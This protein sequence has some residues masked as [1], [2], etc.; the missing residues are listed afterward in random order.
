MAY[1]F[2]W[3]IFFKNILIFIQKKV[4]CNLIDICLIG[5]QLLERLEWIHSK[6][7]IYR[8]IKPENFLLGLK[9]Q[10]MIY[11]VDFGM[12][13]KYRSSKT[14]KHILPKIN[15]TFSGTVRYASLNVLRGKTASRRD[16]LISLGYM[17][18][19][20]YKRELPWDF[21]MPHY[22]MD[23]M[24]QIMHL[25]NNN[26]YGI[27]FKDLP[28]QFEEYIKYTRN[29]KFEQN[30]D[31]S[32]LRSLF[33]KIIMGFY[34]DYKKLSF[35]WTNSKNKLF[36]PSNTYLRKATSHNRLLKRIKESSLNRAKRDIS[37]D[38]YSKKFVSPFIL[39]SKNNVISTLDVMSNNNSGTKIHNL[40]ISNN[41]TINENDS[42]ENNF[43]NNLTKNNNMNKKANTFKI[44]N[45]LTNFN[46]NNNNNINNRNSFI[47][48]KSIKN[49]KNNFIQ[50]NNHKNNIIQKS[51]TTN[52][53]NDIIKKNRYTINNVNNYIDNNN[54]NNNN[55]INKNN[56]SFLNSKV[57]KNNLVNN[58]NLKTTNNKSP[59]KKIHIPKNININNVSHLK[60][61]PK[62]YNT[63][64][65]NNNYRTINVQKMNYIKHYNTEKNQNKINL[66]IKSKQT[67]PPFINN[68]N[69]KLLNIN[70]IGNKNNNLKTRENNKLNAHEKKNN[71]KNLVK[72]KVNSCNVI[73]KKINNNYNTKPDNFI[74]INN[75]MYESPLKNLFKKIEKKTI[76]PSQNYQIRLK[77]N[78]QRKSVKSN[79]GIHLTD[80]NNNNINSR[81]FCI[82][83]SY[84]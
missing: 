5:I 31:Y 78:P 63:I 61:N 69:K 60:K 49:N 22:N 14:G 35:S 20:L 12:C 51:H 54:N 7:I 84:N 38:V 39:Q 67:S 80:I 46:E 64:N 83:N 17:L 56:N 45:V 73:I 30:P 2:N 75:L 8:D 13:K 57:I 72:D 47:D 81:E 68:V 50:N 25:K 4:R 82:Y 21:N 9:N 71:N 10:N 76:F 65:I 11:V 24:I 18:I 62:I 52:N 1:L 79:L 16:D 55:N 33:N 74:F 70:I 43:K 59:Y 36:I 58:K 29:L 23:K 53:S 77:K 66:Y 48:N 34:Y 44:I 41:S 19:Y 42:K 6:D 26:G 3:F 28:H 37:Q 32:Y 27:L 40:I 15:R